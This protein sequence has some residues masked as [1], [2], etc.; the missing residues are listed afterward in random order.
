MHYV[1]PVIITV[2][3]G[4]V[5]TQDLCDPKAMHNSPYSETI[6]YINGFLNISITVVNRHGISVVIPPDPPAHGK[7]NNLFIIRRKIVIERSV[8]QSV[9]NSLI[10]LDDNNPDTGETVKA[11]KKMIDEHGNPVFN[12]NRFEVSLDTVITYEDLRKTGG[13]LYSNETDLVLSMKGASYRPVHPQSLEYSRTMRLID[14]IEKTNVGNLYYRIEIVDNFGTFG[15][16]FMRIGENVF[17]IV[18]IKDNLRR[19]GIY[20]TQNTPALGNNSYTELKESFYELEKGEEELKLY[21]TFEQAR[22]NDE[23]QQ[24]KQKIELEG[25]K[26]ETAKEKLNL[27]K[28]KNF[29]ESFKTGLGAFIT[30]LGGVATIY[31]IALTV[32]TVSAKK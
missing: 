18:P 8:M 13:V 19:S 14:S 5:L 24:L 11:M 7:Y 22:F 9:V 31:K 12:H 4:T 1:D 20:V 27:E 2:H 25:M 29:A 15:T 6:D 32:A 21:R 28:E 30:I 3:G 16:R 23:D 10:R 17:S 26:H